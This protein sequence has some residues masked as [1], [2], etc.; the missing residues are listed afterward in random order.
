MAT[1]ELLAKAVYTRN[2]RKKKRPTDYFI[3]YDIKELNQK[4]F[5]ESR[6]KNKGVFGGNRSG[7]TLCGA[8]YVIKYCLD[9]EGAD[10][11]AATW[12]DLSIPI[13]QKMYYEW[14][15]KDRSVKYAN[16]SNKRGFANRVIEFANGSMIRFKTYDQ[17]RESFQGAAKDIIHL[18][19]EPKE[20][21]VNECK[22]RLID[23]SGTLIRTMTP[24]NGITYTSDEFLE[25]ESNDLEVQYWFWDN[26]YNKEIDQDA[27]QRIIG[28]FAEREAEV[29]QT[30]H[31]LNL[32]TGNAYYAFSEE[33]IIP[34]F[35]Y[36]KRRPLEIDC[37]FNVDLMCWNISQEKEGKDYTFDFVEIENEANTDYLCQVLKNKYPEHEG[38]FHFY[39]DISGNK[40]D[41]AASKTNWAIIREHFPNAEID[42]QQI[43]NIKDRVDAVNG[44]LKNSNGIFWYITRNCKRLIKDLR[45]V[46]WEHLLNKNKAGKLTHAS[47]GASYRLFWKFPLTPKKRSKQW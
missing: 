15:P 42:Y 35:E 11:W 5:F 27:L 24:L 32:T 6:K 33:N 39:G 46:T 12:A 43:R 23:R 21:I 38:G 26:R 9:N 1:K 18:D 20:D 4:A 30:G 10:C 28:G 36:M 37:D 22:A 34:D 31:F 19:E 47:D 45:Q 41:P 44:R 40:R 7:K 13:Q 17:G 25:N 8:V 14:L 16:Y 29:R 2:L 3:P